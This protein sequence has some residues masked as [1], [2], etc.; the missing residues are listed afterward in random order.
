MA[1]TLAVRFPMGRYHATPWGR[2]VNEGEVEWPPSPW[3]ISRSL[4]A[5]WKARA[6]DLDEGTVHEILE[7]LADAP[8]YSLPP[9]SIAHTRHYMPDIKSGTDKALDAFASVDRQSDL[10]VTWPGDL[11]DAAAD[12]LS[13]L[14]SLLPYLGRADS[15]CEMRLVEET[16]QARLAD[17]EQAG[18]ISPVSDGDALPDRVVRVLVPDRPLDIETLTARTTAVRKG[19]R[20]D[21]PGTSWV[22]Y[23][24]ADTEVKPA[25]IQTPSRSSATAVRWSIA[26]P[27]LPARTAA[28]VM[29]DVLRQACMSK[30]GRRFDE[31]ASQSL[32][33][34]DQAGSP[35]AGHSHAH[36]IAFGADPKRGGDTLLDTFVIWAPG[37]L[38]PD[39]LDAVGDLRAL[40][41]RAFL[42]DF[43]ACRLGLEGVGPVEDVAPE[44]IGPATVWESYTPF[45]TARHRGKKQTWE[46][47]M[48]AEVRRECGYRDLPAPLSVELLSESDSNRRVS[49]GWLDFRRHRAK[50]SLRQAHRAT[51]FRIVFESPVTGPICI[52]ALS[53]Y[54]L[55]LFLPVKER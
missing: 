45:A 33:G 49:G 37:G 21:P 16:E 22:D 20:L 38:T 47:H 10:V 1:V 6:P 48:A 55:G 2:N 30:Y 9:C 26:S 36:Y 34:K 43:Q 46:Q 3:R 51:G 32:A 40:N 39:D 23:P 50:A 18:V 42:K 41:G 17:S 8:R 5:T 12:A 11:N 14:C 4:Y 7:V 29:C 25:P 13:Q 31:G 54:G 28:V 24:E 19:K 44:I 27:A 15:I 35:L 53:H 52:G